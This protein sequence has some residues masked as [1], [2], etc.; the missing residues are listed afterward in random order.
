[1]FGGLRPDELRRIPARLRNQFMRTRT[2]QRL[3]AP[4]GTP[5]DG[6]KWIFVLG[7]Y[8]SG[9]TLL[10]D[11]LAAHPDIGALPGEGVRFTD[12]LPRPEEFG[13]NRMWCRCLDQIRLR[14]GPGMEARAQ[15]IKRQWSIIYPSDPPYL[16]EKSVA[17]AVRTDFLQTYF[18]P[19]YFIYLV[20][21]GYA[22]AE[23]I[24][25]KGNPARYEDATYP[26]SYPIELCAEQWCA[27]DRILMAE[28][29]R[30]E[31]FLCLKYE[32]LAAAPDG[33]LQKVTDFL[34]LD[35]LGD[36]QLQR[37]WRVH[38]VHSEI[39]D[40]NEGALDRLSDEDMAK[41]REVAGDELEK[42]G[43]SSPTR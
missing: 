26:S 4:F 18:A 32:E 37:R 14:P 3:A 24:R 33:S 1:M 43:Y 40:M 19:A 5:L 7:C 23:G 6:K 13:W 39:R 28:R 38:G 27:T 34:G 10:R 17:N 15:R 22:V 20:R 31:R 25:R 8:N 16:L 36:E 12:A 11:I 30:L 41:I 2:G 42:Y 9:T 21:N 35:P 29:P